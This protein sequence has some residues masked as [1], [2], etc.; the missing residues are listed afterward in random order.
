MKMA[1]YKKPQDRSIDSDY[2]EDEADQFEVA[3]LAKKMT[4]EEAAKLWTDRFLGVSKLEYLYVIHKT[5]PVKMPRPVTNLQ[6]GLG[7]KIWAMVNVMR[8]IMMK[9]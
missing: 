8:N 2:S 1:L 6:A 7:T 3:K 5:W 9:V 4:N